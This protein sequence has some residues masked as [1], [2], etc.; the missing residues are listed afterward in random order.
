MNYSRLIILSTMVFSFTFS[1][2]S[3]AE[4]LMTV[5]VKE[6]KLRSAPQQWASSISSLRYGDTLTA[7]KV[8]NNWVSGLTKSKQKGFVHISALTSKTIVLSSNKIASNTV[9]PTDVILAGKGFSQA[10][11]NEY[12]RKNGASN[13]K[14]VDTVQTLQVVDSELIGFMRDGHIGEGAK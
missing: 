5:Q 4:N 9:D 10:T 12:A 7:E 14:A 11:E 6:T 3:S 13:F 1:T 8:E 2:L